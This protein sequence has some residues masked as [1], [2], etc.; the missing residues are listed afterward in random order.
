MLSSAI[1]KEGVKNVNMLV[2]IVQSQFQLEC[3]R[4]GIY[5]QHFA[6]KESF[7]LLSYTLQNIKYLKIILQT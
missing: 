1:R 7:Q 3:I 2:F 4:I 5:V 6:K